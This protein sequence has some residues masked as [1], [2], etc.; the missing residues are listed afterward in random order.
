MFEFLNREKT[1][2]RTQVAQLQAELRSRELRCC[3]LRNECAS[4]AKMSKDLA[5]YLKTAQD[6]LQNLYEINERHR[7]SHARL[8]EENKRLCGE[9]QRMRDERQLLYPPVA[10][11][12]PPATA[13]SNASA[14]PPVPVARSA[15]P[16]PALSA[17]MLAA[18]AA[19]PTAP[20]PRGQA[21]ATG[22][23]S[24]RP[25][26]AQPSRL[27]PVPLVIEHPDFEA[28]PFQPATQSRP[29]QPVAP[30]QPELREFLA[31]DSGSEPPKLAAPTRTVYYKVRDKCQRFY[32]L[33]LGPIVAGLVEYQEECAAV[34]VYITDDYGALCDH[35][36]FV[37]FNRIL[38]HNGV[39]SVSYQDYC[40]VKTV[41]LLSLSDHVRWTGAVAEITGIARIYVTKSGKIPCATPPPIWFLIPTARQVLAAR[42]AA[43]DPAIAWVALVEQ[44]AV[45]RDAGAQGS[46]ARSTSARGAGSP[47]FVRRPKIA[48]HL[49]IAAARLPHSPATIWDAWLARLKVHDWADRLEWFALAPEPC[50]RDYIARYGVR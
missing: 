10:A 5:K 16:S 40:H 9:L 32:G 46:S 11:A 15:R 28:A 42:A 26:P 33:V 47:C 14:A 7:R 49:S 31:A 4:A 20:R 23:T 38:E 6:D 8:A 13:L 25:A 17:A 44:V 12:A 37:M 35:T 48:E 36:L 1:W 45:C 43:I 41:K 39:P 19:A 24:T 30:P 21:P 29:P 22:P 2:L 18:A 50:L 34:G 3:E 27:A